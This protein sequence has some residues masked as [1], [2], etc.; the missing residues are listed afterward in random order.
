MQTFG[1]REP[2]VRTSDGKS[3]SHS[4]KA[5]KPVTLLSFCEEIWIAMLQERRDDHQTQRAPGQDADEA[6]TSHRQVG[7]QRCTATAQRGPRP[8]H[9]GALRQ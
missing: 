2:I 4:G 5:E 7:A 6:Q 3:L 9:A 8:G 1:P